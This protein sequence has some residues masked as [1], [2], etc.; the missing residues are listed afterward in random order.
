[1]VLALPISEQ[2]SE[3][4]CANLVNDKKDFL[5]NTPLVIYNIGRGIREASNLFSYP[6]LGHYRLSEQYLNT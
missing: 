5:T 6:I 3:A 1:M 4:F 2:T